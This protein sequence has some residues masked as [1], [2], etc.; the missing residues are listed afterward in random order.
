MHPDCYVSRKLQKLKIYSKDVLFP[1][2]SG[3][4]AVCGSLLAGAAGKPTK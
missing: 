2:G 1:C 4:Q 3:A